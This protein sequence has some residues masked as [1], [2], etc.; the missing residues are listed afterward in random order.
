MERNNLSLYPDFNET[1]KI[2][3]NDSAFQLGVVVS[4][5]GKPIDFYIRKLTDAQQRYTETER[6]L[7]STV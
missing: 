7:L 6:Y 1:F 2:N 4:Q 5:K 3:T